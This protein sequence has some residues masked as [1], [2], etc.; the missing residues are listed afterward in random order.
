MPQHYAQIAF[1][2]DVKNAQDRLGSRSSMRRF[3]DADVD[4]DRLGPDE[5]A[6]VRE[7]DGFYL[8]T[9]SSNGWPYVQFRGGPAG[10]LHVLDDRTLGWAD[11]RGN[12]QY[13][14]TG[15]A[16]S[17]DRVSLFLMD[18]AHRGRLKVYGRLELRPADEA[19]PLYAALVLPEYHARVEQL[20]VVHVE[21]LDWNCSQHI[22][23]RF[24]A[25]ELAALREQAAR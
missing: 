14:S 9:V 23:P 5:R 2:D 15:N 10:F 8:A 21:A 19:D 13:I 1:T 12:R 22:T 7:R 4:N 16:V 3:E 17:N 6:F 18:Y 24:S 11:F 20:A 25:A